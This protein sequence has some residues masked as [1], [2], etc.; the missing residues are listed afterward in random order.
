MIKTKYI[1]ALTETHS[2]II[3][4]YGEDN[5]GRL[6]G[7]HETGNYNNFTW[8]DGSRGGSV[9]VPIYTIVHNAGYIK[10]NNF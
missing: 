4:L 2:K 5:E 6:T 3:K 9:R 10:I 8:G 7:N 1:D